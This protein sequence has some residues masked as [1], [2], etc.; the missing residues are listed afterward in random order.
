MILVR[1][2]INTINT[3]NSLKKYGPDTGTDT[4]YSALIVELSSP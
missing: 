3:I 4:R 2:K 1:T